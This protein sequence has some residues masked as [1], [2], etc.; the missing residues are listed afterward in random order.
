MIRRR[1]TLDLTDYRSVLATTGDLEVGAYARRQQRR[2]ILIALGGLGLIAA[3]YWLFAQLSVID[4]GIGQD[5]YEVKVR[6][7]SCSYAGR[8]EVPLDQTFPT[9]CPECG[10]RALR[11]VW[12]CRECRTE[13]L[14]KPGAPRVRCPSCGSEKVGSALPKKVPKSAKSSGARK[15]SGG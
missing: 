9:I 15:G 14:P 1:R 12:E 6:C 4:P 2:R 3:A 7:V 8:V 10:Q 11:R 5:R 13:F